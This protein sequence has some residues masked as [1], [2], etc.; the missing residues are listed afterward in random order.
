MDPAVFNLIIELQF[1]DKEFDDTF[2]CF[3]ILPSF[4]T[5]LTTPKDTDE[6]QLRI[7]DEWR[8]N[9]AS[10]VLEMLM[11][12]DVSNAP[13]DHIKML[14]ENTTVKGYLPG[15]DLDMKNITTDKTLQSTLNDTMVLGNGYLT[16][17]AETNKWIIPTSWYRGDL[18]SVD[19]MTEGASIDSPVANKPDDK[20]DDSNFYAVSYTHLTLPTICSV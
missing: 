5:K 3:E 4:L 13:E 9:V 1:N 15:V 2:G 20:Y 19:I 14:L 10:I 17:I 8:S 16:L 6:P 11:L 18:S 7:H 12:Q